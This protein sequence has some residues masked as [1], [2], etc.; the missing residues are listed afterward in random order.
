MDADQEQNLARD[1]H[2]LAKRFICA[3]PRKSAA[4]FDLQGL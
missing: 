4:L 3:A 2:G 1:D